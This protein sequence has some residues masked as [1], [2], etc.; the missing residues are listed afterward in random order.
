[1]T[2][3]V[4]LITP[5]FY[6]IEKE[7][8]SVLEESDYEVTWLENRTLPF[9]YHGTKSKF[10]LLRKI[11]FLLFLPQVRYLRKELRK[12]ENI[13]FDI[14]F[15]INA[16]IIC[17][18]LF[19]KLKKRNQKL[20]S[21]L[22]LWDSFSMYNWIKEARLFNKVYTFDTADSIKYKIEY[23]PNFYIKNNYNTIS[24]N[25]YDM[26]FMGKFSSERLL[27]IRK[28]LNHPDMAGVRCFLKL[29]PA[30]KILFHNHL[31]YKIFKLFNLKSK[32][33]KNFIINFEAV[34]GILPG[35]YISTDYMNYKEMQS[36][37]LR[38]NVILDI[39][40]QFQTGFTHR[41]I[42]A[43]A[44]GKKVITTNQNIRN[45]SFYNP[46]QIHILDTQSPEI[47]IRWIKTKSVFQI[48]AYFPDLELSAWLKSTFDVAI[49]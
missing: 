8:K 4:L 22:Y 35:E 1:M 9:D 31:I 32:W 19:R 11:Y 29:W 7:I 37:L 38:S 28:I 26:F 34:E 5:R 48:N 16:H 24:E 23:K 43:L 39:Q 15:S 45:E 49:A 21:V 25:E 14:L 18:Y 33:V 6:E 17:P 12:N 42:E 13:K 30:Y 3:R 47:D 46:E 44:N 40:Y 10:R 41:L 20:Y 27:I 36:H 2:V